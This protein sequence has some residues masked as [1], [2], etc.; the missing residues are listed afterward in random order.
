MAQNQQKIRLTIDQTHALGA[1]VA[2]AGGLGT[3]ALMC[4]Q[5]YAGTGKTTV[6]AHAV[7]EL[8]GHGRRIAIAAPTNKAVGVLQEKIGEI[9]GVTFGSIHSFIGMRLRENEDGTMSCWA[10]GIPSMHLYD[11]AVIDECSMIGTQL[12]SDI[13]MQRRSCRVLFVGDPAQLPPV[14]ERNDSPVFRH[15]AN[16]VRLTR[17]VRQAQD[18]PIIAASAAVREAIEDG[19]RVTI[20]DLVFPQPPS[21]AGVVSGG[22]SAIVDI[23]VHEA[24]AG[25]DCRALAWRNRRVAD[26][27]AI[28]HDALHPSCRTPFAPG[29]RV[30]ALAEFQASDAESGA[31][32]RVF[33]SEELTVVGMDDGEHH[34]FAAWKALLMREGGE[35]VCAY[36]PRKPDEL[37]HHLTALWAQYRAA[38]AKNEYAKARTLSGSAWA[39]QRAFAPIAHAYAMTVHKSQGSTFD[40]ALIDWQDASRQRDD[41]EFNRMIYVAMTRAA[42]HM[43]IVT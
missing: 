11:L 35:I 15:V 40:T 19:R 12:F 13:V 25:R 10:D 41:Y 5:G 21:A 36:V 26:I 2:F 32:R 7:R 30:Y 8:A 42:K 43:A 14:G 17:I 33:N 27:N 31:S 37:R 22:L 4:L 39:I 6:V 16:T 20:G 9:E 24:R 28:V 29:E 38:K 34:G 1:I 23:L 3:S 18:N